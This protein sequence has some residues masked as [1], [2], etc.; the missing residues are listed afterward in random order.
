MLISPNSKIFLYRHA[1]D[2]RKSYDSLIS[3]VEYVLKENPTSGAYF[4]FLNIPRN[5]IKILYW[6]EDGFAIWMKRLERGSFR[7]PDSDIDDKELLDIA[8]Y[9]ALLN[10]VEITKKYRRFKLK[11]S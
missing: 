2:L 8:T 5:R 7:F 9:N 1:V 3:L 10:G 11:N 6:D 4:I